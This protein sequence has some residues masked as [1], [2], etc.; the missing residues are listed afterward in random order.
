MKSPE[1]K[2]GQG[3]I[4]TENENPVQKEIEKQSCEG[5]GLWSI[6]FFFLFKN[7]RRTS[8]EPRV[9]LSLWIQ[10]TFLLGHTEY[11]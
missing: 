5:C 6:F 4:E 1:I 8:N 3:F 10:E 9:V 11:Y 7:Q 2:Q